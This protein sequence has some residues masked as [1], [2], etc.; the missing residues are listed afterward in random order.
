MRLETLPPLGKADPGTRAPETPFDIAAVARNARLLE[1]TGYDGLVC[2]ETKDD[3]FIVLALAARAT[4][5][6]FKCPS[7]KSSSLS[8]FIPRPGRGVTWKRVTWRKTI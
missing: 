3:P 1:D 8:S 6:N 2:E 7:G 5:R 4:E